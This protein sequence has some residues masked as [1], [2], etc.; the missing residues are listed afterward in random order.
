MLGGSAPVPIDDRSARGTD[1]VA[2]DVQPILAAVHRIC[3]SNV[4]KFRTSKIL[5][6]ETI[7]YPRELGILGYERICCRSQNC[8]M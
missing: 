8:V 2:T 3:C 7:Q 5:N 6:L 1:A 4:C